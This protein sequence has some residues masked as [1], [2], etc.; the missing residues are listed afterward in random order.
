L[1]G[2]VLEREGSKT[3]PGAEDDEDDEDGEDGK[4][5]KDGEDGEDD[6][7]SRRVIVAGRA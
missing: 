6:E 4:D 3:G 5:G 7:E 1:S 2:V